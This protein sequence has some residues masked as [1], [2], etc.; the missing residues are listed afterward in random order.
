VPSHAT[1][2]T[3]ITGAVSSNTGTPS[4][5]HSTP[6]VLT[7]KPL[8]HAM[9]RLPFQRILEKLLRSELTSSQAIPSLEV[10][11]LLPTATALVP[12]QATSRK[13][14]SREPRHTDQLTPSAVLF[15]PCPPVTTNVLPTQST[16]RTPSVSGGSTQC[17]SS[18]S[19]LQAT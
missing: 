17:Q 11:M 15:S 10:A 18:P 2:L 13:Y 12:S 4:G 9:N 8:S 1:S 6:S 14:E 19:R 16:E 3:D 5:R 7:V